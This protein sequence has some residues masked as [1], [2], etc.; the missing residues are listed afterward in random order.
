MYTAPPFVRRV[1]YRRSATPHLPC[2]TIAPLF[3]SFVPRPLSRRG[4]TL[5]ELLVVITIIGILI[6]L[7]LPAVQAAREA[8]RRMQCGNNLKQISLA[9]ASYEAA[10]GAFPPG[11]LKM[12]GSSG[13]GFSW[14]VRVLPYLEAQNMY[15]RLDWVGANCG[16][17]LGWL[18]TTASTSAANKTNHD[19]LFK[20]GP[21][22]GFCPSSPMKALNMQSTGV[23]YSTKFSPT[24]TGIS[25]AADDPT[26][27][28]AT[29]SGMGTLGTISH[30]GMLYS[31]ALQKLDIDRRSTSVRGDA[32]HRRWHVSH[33]NRR[34]TVGLVLRL[35]RCRLGVTQRLLPRLYNGT[36]KLRSRRHAKFQHDDCIAS[37]G[38]KSGGYHRWLYFQRRRPQLRRKPAYSVGPCQWRLCGHG[39]WI[40]PIPQRHPR[41]KSFLQSGE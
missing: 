34:R 35:E 11:G 40:R 18:G 25:G 9:L 4:F 12:G 41:D 13:Y 33:N 7:L 39:R 21:A 36:W 20:W 31:N 14:W 32:R 28:T 26:A 16:T 27:A 5:V 30:G 23:E 24:Y 2:Q 10:N 22:C 15:D 6:A 1:R 8:A 17:T 29:L 37:V 19:V 38:R 3:S